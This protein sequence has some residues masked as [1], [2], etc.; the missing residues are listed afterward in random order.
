MHLE[1]ERVEKILSQSDEE[2]RPKVQ[3]V[4][5]ALGLSGHLQR[6]ILRDLPALRQKAE[7]FTQEDFERLQQALGE[8]TVR[9][10]IGML[11]HGNK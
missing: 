6:Q 1:Q 9:E 4:M 8:D 7:E 3:A 10:L 2:L 5:G 11:D